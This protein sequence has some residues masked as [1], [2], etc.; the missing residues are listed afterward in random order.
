MTLIVYKKYKN[1]TILA[2]DRQTTWDGFIENDNCVKIEHYGNYVFAGGGACSSVPIFKRALQ[3]A[4]KKEGSLDINLSEEETGIVKTDDKE[5]DTDQF[6]SYI[7]LQLDSMGI[8]QEAL[9]VEVGYNISVQNLKI[10]QQELAVIGSGTKSF[11][12][13]FISK[14]KDTWEQTLKAVK[15]AMI[16]TS[17]VN[18]YCNDN[19]DMRVF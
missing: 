5:H 19:I 7:L 11:L 18:I 4:S 12:G 13:A 6:G 15:D 10:E 17:K 2:S 3:A 8:A 1:K 9:Y 14:K 16:D